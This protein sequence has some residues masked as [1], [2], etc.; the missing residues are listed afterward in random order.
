MKKFLAAAAVA[1]LGGLSLPASADVVTGLHLE[2]ASGAVFDG[3]VTFTD[4]Y[5]ALIDVAGTL[6]GGSYSPTFYGWT[7]WQGSSQANPRDYDGD[8]STYEDLLMAG[9]AAPGFTD[10]IGISWFH[11]SPGDAPVLNL[12]PGDNPSANYWRSVSSNQ[13]VT[14][15]GYFGNTAV[16]EPGSIALVGLALL[17]ACVAGRRKAVAA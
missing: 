7:W 15:S 12:N 16:P 6:S 4:N 14:V 9:A 11:G 3:S 8:A 2:F 13:D 17:G 5:G 10:Y 1:A